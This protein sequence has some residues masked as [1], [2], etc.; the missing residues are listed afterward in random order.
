MIGRPAAAVTIRAAA[1]ATAL[2]WL[3]ID[4]TSVSSTT[5]SAKVPR[6]REHRRVREVELALGVAVDVAGEPVVGAGTPPMAS[7]TTPS[8]TQEPTVLVVEG[9]VG[10]RLEQPAGAGDDAVA[11]SVRQPPREH[12]EDAAPVGGAVAQRRAEHGQLVPVGE[13]SG[14]HPARPGPMTAPIPP[15][16]KPVNAAQRPQL[17]L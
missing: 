13:Q 11:P 2:S 3:R 9:E 15:M 17:E 4:S 10:Q 7:S 8:A 14:A 1:E 6:D 12:L 5:A 16:T